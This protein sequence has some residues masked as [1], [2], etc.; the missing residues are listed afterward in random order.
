MYSLREYTFMHLYVFGI[1]PRVPVERPGLVGALAQRWCSEWHGV[2]PD[3]ELQQLGAD[4]GVKLFGAVGVIYT[5]YTYTLYTYTLYIYI[6][7]I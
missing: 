4:L 1:G 7:N 3:V 2:R 6:Y 5:L